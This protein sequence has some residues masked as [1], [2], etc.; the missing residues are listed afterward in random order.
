MSNKIVS[1]VQYA[2]NERGAPKKCSK[3]T[4]HNLLLILIY[5][6]KVWNG[7]VGFWQN[8]LILET[9]VN[10]AAYAKHRRHISV[11]TSSQRQ[12][13]SL[14]EAYGPYPSFDDIG[15]FGL[16]Y[17]RIYEVLGIRKFL[18]TSKDIFIWVW[19]TGWD[20]EGH[21]GG[22][23]WFDNEFRSKQTITNLIYFQLA[24]RL[25]RLTKD[26]YYLERL[27]LIYHYISVNKLVNETTYLIND[28]ATS[29]CGPNQYYGPSYLS[30]T[31]IGGLVE[32][33]KVLR[34]RSLLDLAV[35]IAD[36]II[37]YSTSKTG[38]FTEYCEPNC[39]RDQIFLKEYLYG[40]SGTC[41][42]P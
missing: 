17:S 13:K 24:G 1:D 29:N 11:V 22:G 26:P 39:N 3:I 4:H 18:D 31:M 20:H 28:G 40:I 2:S 12:L 37:A 21:C 6:L 36:A 33:Y 38:I 42:T 23:F 30:G 7:Y 9:M 35:K 27:N 8:G 34:K 5:F 16:S 19:K 41:W 25:F 15:W 14:L 10:F 32:M